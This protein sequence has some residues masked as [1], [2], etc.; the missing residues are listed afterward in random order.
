[1]FDAQVSFSGDGSAQKMRLSDGKITVNATPKDGGLTLSIEAREWQP[2]FG[3]ALQF[4][5]LSINAQIGRQ[6]AT[7]SSI[8]GRLGGGRLKGA[9]KATWNSDIRIEGEFNLE[10]G[11]LQQLLPAYTRKFSATGNL[12]TNGSYALQGKSLQTLFDANEAEAT[13]TIDAGEL[14][15]VDLVRAI[16]SPA[17]PV[18]AKPNS[19]PWPEPSASA[20]DVT[21]TSSCSWLL[22]RS[23]PPARSMSAATAA[24]PGV[25]TPN[26]ARKVS[27]SPAAV[28]TSPA[29]WATPCSVPDPACA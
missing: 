4:S 2:P 5:D 27:S 25:S 22:A 15:N 29:T 21:P 12:N 11:K 10:G 17:A 7:L 20:T 16:Q 24:L 28:S 8:D 23:T 19:T 14:V 9:A 1:M 18:A 26:W 13:F 3:P 6:Q